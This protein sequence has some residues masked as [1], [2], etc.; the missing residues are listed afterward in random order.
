M[1]LRG[2]TNP[3][4]KGNMP[5]ASLG[6]PTAF[7]SSFHSQSRLRKLTLRDSIVKMLWP[8]Q[9]KSLLH[10]SSSTLTYLSLFHGDALA[11]KWA[12]AISQCRLPMLQEFGIYDTN[13]PV[14]I[15]VS[16]LL[17]NPSILTAEICLQVGYR[18]PSG[19]CLK[20]RS[21]DRAR[22]LPRLR[23]L[24]AT[25][26][27]LL[28]LFNSTS[29]TGPDIPLFNLETLD[30][31]TIPT[32]STPERPKPDYSGLT[33]VLVRIPTPNTQEKKSLIALRTVKLELPRG[34]ATELWLD[35][36]SDMRSSPCEAKMA[37]T[38]SHPYSRPHPI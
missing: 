11:S 31:V 21:G 10:H 30:I 34:P 12:A 33:K 32:H 13:L 36:G 15:L 19:S 29:G 27:S 23:K 35:S 2:D 26:D 3:D 25:T 6:P 37:Q 5:E 24:S 9:I 16:F 14:N 22:F 8:S 4:V 1:H 18:L 28:A 38:S 17:L 7:P 20:M